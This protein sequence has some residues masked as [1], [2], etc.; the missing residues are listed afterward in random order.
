MMRQWNGQAVMKCL[1]KSEPFDLGVKSASH[2]CLCSE[3][4]NQGVM[5][6]EDDE[7]KSKG[8]ITDHYTYNE[9]LEL[10]GS[11]CCQYC[12]NWYKHA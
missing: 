5:T 2:V 4:K 10:E 9:T 6:I 8:C 12:S 1:N 7:L 3:L 11:R